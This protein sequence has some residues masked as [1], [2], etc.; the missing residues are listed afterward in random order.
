[1]NIGIGVVVGNGSYD[2][3][4]GKS[5]PPSTKPFLTI[6]RCSCGKHIKKMAVS[7]ERSRR[8]LVEWPFCTFRV[9]FAAW[10]N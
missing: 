7:S 1:M 9:L 3:W 6:G 10:P 2:H 8:Q 4:Y 5:G